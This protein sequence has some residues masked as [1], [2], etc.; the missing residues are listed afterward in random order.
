MQFSAYGK[1]DI[2]VGRPSNQDRFVIDGLMKFA[3]V[4][5][6]AGGQRAGH[7]A[8][9]AAA[10]IVRETIRDHHPLLRELYRQPNEGGYFDEIERLLR[11]AVC[12]ANSE[13]HEQSTAD[14]AL[15]G[16]CTTCTLI[17]ILGEHA[18]IAHVGD[19]RC[20]RV[21]G[22]DV[23]QLTRDHTYGEM[24]ERLADAQSAALVSGYANILTRAV[25]ARPSLEVDVS[26]VR[27]EAGDRFI[28]CSDGVSKVCDIPTVVAEL[29]ETSH[30][31]VLVERLIDSALDRST[32]DNATAVVIALEKA[33][34]SIK[35]GPRRSGDSRISAQ[36]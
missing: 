10:R 32:R 18:F 36:F 22:T 6:G 23:Q 3:V 24:L 11:D 7:V 26:W 21:R 17:Q 2:G 1:S 33:A 19:S 13:I 29:G 34:A 8:A 30:R 15:R 20:Y 9:E 35:N 28:L 14:D 5:D 4:C 27:I 25:G 16:M 12:R 31:A